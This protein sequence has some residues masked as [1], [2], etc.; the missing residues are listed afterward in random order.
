[1]QADHPQLHLADSNVEL[2]LKSDIIFLCV[3]PK[4]YKVVIDDIKDVLL[5]QQ[6]L[7]SITSPILI[8]HLED[9]LP[10]KI[11]KVIPSITNFSREGPTLC[12]F[13]RRINDFDREKL[14]Q[15]LQTFSTPL[16]IAE[17]YTR[18]SSDITSCGPAFLCYF[19]QQLV[20]AAHH[21]T[22][23][24]K[25]EATRLASEMVL[26]TGKLLTSGGFTPESL[27]ERVSVPG[28]ITTAGLRLMSE[29]LDGLFNRLIQATHKKYYDDLDQVETLFYSTRI[30]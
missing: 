5:P 24:D 2:V 9:Q 13:G 28:G 12:I 20:D 6:I 27:Q 18:V 23:I 22:G 15:L 14:E 19:V 30:D 26:G 1:M 25:A 17:E 16:H 7:V 10:C 29:E 3:K 8:R 11:A 4:E 21:E